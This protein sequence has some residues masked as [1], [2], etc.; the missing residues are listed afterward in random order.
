MKTL[1]EGRNRRRR[2]RG[3]PQAVSSGYLTFSRAFHIVK[4][5]KQIYGGM[6]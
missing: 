4:E 6:I 1:R 3:P 2:L 5:K